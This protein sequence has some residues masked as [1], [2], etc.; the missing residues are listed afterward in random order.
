VDRAYSRINTGVNS[1]WVEI[2]TGDEQG[3]NRRDNRE[4][5]LKNR[6]SFAVSFLAASILLELLTPWFFL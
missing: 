2:V 5:M 1:F 6:S 4:K 3:N